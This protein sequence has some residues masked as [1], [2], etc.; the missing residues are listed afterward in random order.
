MVTRSETSALGADGALYADLR[1]DMDD[2]GPQF[3][4]EFGWESRDGLFCDKDWSD[5]ID[6]NFCPFCGTQLRKELV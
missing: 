6:I 1:L 2:G 3:D 4:I 5:V